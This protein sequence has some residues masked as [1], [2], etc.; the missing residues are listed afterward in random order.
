M[1]AIRRILVAIKDPGARTFPAV[2][3][4]AQIATALGSK[5]EL[6]HDMTTT[7]YTGFPG[8]IASDPHAFEREHRAARLDQLEKIAA[9]LRDRGLN[10]SIAAEWDYPAHEAIVRRAMKVKADL[11]VAQHHPSKHHLTWLLSFTDWELLRLSPMPVLLVK[12][13]QPYRHPVVLAAVDPLHAFG[14]H[15]RLDTRILRL[16][17]V[18]AEGLRGKLHAVH[19]Y[20]TLPVSVAAADGRI[21]MELQREAAGIARAAFDHVLRS[22]KIP[23]PRRHLV[24][25]DPASCIATVSRKTGSAIV[26]LGALSRSGLKRAFIGNT[27]ER[28]IDELRGDLL[29]VKPA[30]FTVKVPRGQRGVRLAPSP[31]PMP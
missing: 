30:H 12:S 14:K 29:V 27:A 6:F 20:A 16:G 24:E 31:A 17:A 22:T 1:P 3:K 5:I 26:V 9:R 15:S 28:L 13:S 18:M 19:V 10:V 23:R 8:G 11:I 2:A 7:L 25:G 4:A 21:G